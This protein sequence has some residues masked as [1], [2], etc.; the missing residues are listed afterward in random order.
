MIDDDTIDLIRGFEIGTDQI[1]VSAWGATGLADLTIKDLVRKD[2]SVSW[3]LI[4]DQD[5]N[6]ETLLRY[7]SDTPLSSALLSESDFVFSA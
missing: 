1:D 7:S 6:A 3:I 2:G 4:Q 5:G